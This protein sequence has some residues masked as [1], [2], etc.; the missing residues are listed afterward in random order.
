MNKPK[1]YIKEQQNQSD[2]YK[3]LTIAD[4]QKEPDWLKEALFEDAVVEITRMG[5]IKW[6]NGT[7]KYGLWNS[8]I[9]ID[10]TWENGT[11][12]K[13]MWKNGTWKNGTWEWGVWE[14]GIWENG[15]WENGT[16]NDGVWKRGVI[17]FCKMYNRDTGVDEE[18]YNDKK[19]KYYYGE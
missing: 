14:D 9:W 8:G 5:R 15:I 3:S 1:F 4:G 2:K 10:G 7:W 11:W 17:F 16:W 6:W 12:K 19:M 18:I 13:G